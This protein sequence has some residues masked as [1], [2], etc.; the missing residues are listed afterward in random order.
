ML[1][2]IFHD[3]TSEV[4][5]PE[6]LP[7]L[8]IRTTADFELRLDGELL[9]GEA[10]FPVI[11]LAAALARWADLPAGS[12]PDFEFDSMS[13][14]E[15]GWVWLRRVRD[16]WRVG[17]INQRRSI[18]VAWS[19]SEVQAEIEAFTT[20]VVGCARTSLEIDVGQ[21]IPELTD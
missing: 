3:L 6:S 19:E 7:D 2:L 1:S 4:N 17:S 14:P 9:Y 11:E 18:L 13:T 21:W 12:R 15:P 8:L 5:P 16:G 10:D 20:R